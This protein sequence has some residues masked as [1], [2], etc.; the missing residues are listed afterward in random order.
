MN[1]IGWLLFAHLLLYFTPGMG[2][3]QALQSS[4]PTTPTGFGGVAQ[5]TTSIQWSWGPSTGS[6]IITYEIHAVPE[7]IPATI[8][9]S[10]LSATSYLESGL[11][12]NTAYSRNVYAVASDGVTKS[13]PSNVGRRYTLIHTATTSDFTVTSS[14]SSSIAINVTPPPNPA[15]DQTG[16]Q[17]FRTVP[18]FTQITPFSPVYAASNTG[19]QPKTEYCYNIEFRNGDAIPSGP[20]PSPL[21]ATTDSGTI[22]CMYSINIATGYSKA[23]FKYS[24]TRIGTSHGRFGGGRLVPIGHNKEELTQK[25]TITNHTMDLARNGNQTPIRHEIPNQF[26]VFN[27]ESETNAMITYMGSGQSM[28]DADQVGHAHLSS[29]GDASGFIPPFGKWALASAGALAGLNDIKYTAPFGL[30][31]T[32][33]SSTNGGTADLFVGGDLGKF[34]FAGVGGIPLPLNLPITKKEE[35][36]V[37][38]SG[39]ARGLVKVQYQFTMKNGGGIDSE[40]DASEL[41]LTKCSGEGKF[42]HRLTKLHA[43]DQDGCTIDVELRGDSAKVKIVDSTGVHTFTLVAPEADAQPGSDP[44]DPFPGGVK[45]WQV[46]D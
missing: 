46:S 21:C 5:S 26:R 11:N 45:V 43:H 16:V 18:T 19:L 29:Q 41:T 27:T 23:D 4:P 39:F 40:I 12:E 6:S 1:R 13:P 35:V 10:G 30:P 17:I 37:D 7:T 8:I 15:G 20:G 33:A 14:S 25:G 9:A 36:P 32:F 44:D 38:G 42:H 28:L 22:P 31:V 2:S 3:L 24:D 34:F